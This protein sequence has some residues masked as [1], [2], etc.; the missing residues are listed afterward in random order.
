MLLSQ[1]AQWHC[2]IFRI[3]LQD[4][5]KK[6]SEIYKP[7]IVEQ[8]KAAENSQLKLVYRYEN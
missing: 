5:F 8:A 6:Q 3:L 2:H 4:T 1:E 7:Q